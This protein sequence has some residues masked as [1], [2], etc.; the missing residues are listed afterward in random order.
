MR[1]ARRGFK[2]THLSRLFLLAALLVTLSCDTPSPHIQSIY[3]QTGDLG[4]DI[5][6][7]GEGFGDERGLNAVSIAGIEPTDSSYRVWSDTLIRVQVPHFGDSGLVYVRIGKKQ[8]NPAL[9]TN[10]L[11]IPVPVEQDLDE[12]LPI[13][14]SLSPAKAAP[15][16][17]VVI[18]GKNFGTTRGKGAVLFT[19]AAE[20]A[21]RS[22]PSTE[23]R[24]S[25]EAIAREFA[26]ELWS[27]REIRV[28]VPESAKTGPLIVRTQTGA[29][30]SSRWF[31]TESTVGTRVYRDHRTYAI[32]YSVNYQVQRADSPNRLYL[33]M[34]SPREGNNQ[35]N[36]RIL[37]RT[38]EPFIETDLGYALYQFDNLSP[39]DRK[40][41]RVQRTIDVWA[42]ETGIQARFIKKSTQSPLHASFVL[43]G[44]NIPSDEEE[45]VA[46]AQEITAK[47]RNDYAKAR[48]IY[49][50]L[51]TNI[52][53]AD[54]SSKTSVQEDIQSRQ[55]DPC[56]AALIFC[57]L[58]RAV[59]IP[60]IPV[61]GFLISRNRQSR[62]HWWA[63]FWL[64]DFG[65]VP[66][67]P[68]LGAGSIPPTF[69]FKDNAREYYF[70][71]IDS[72]RIAF[73][74]GMI[75]LSQMDP[76]GRTSSRPKTYAF[77]NIWEEAVGDIHSY[78][79]LWSEL[80]VTGI[81]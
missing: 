80:S 3:P 55:S 39:S 61:A 70:G 54:E 37:S 20:E 33:W 6:I 68:T 59:D 76:R 60:A 8:S 81:Y 29:E 53:I 58:A 78:S 50:W 31:D 7:I 57:T 4:S 38:D 75:N 65:W 66:V 52:F 10:K 15:G 14:S 13:I 67:D 48:S 43:P 17:L 23:A 2:A 77:Q 28:R 21:G 36:S 42:V 9:F 44:T 5:S 34:P 19:W 79:T 35:S 45:L 26:Y 47:D 32:S 22:Q 49:E 46:L 56:N 16:K 64:E 41:I 74:R 71:N 73:S 12:E 18:K 69:V 63:E 72:Q 40:T 62:P 27:D 1:P 11:S 25:V 30:S 24:T 51:L